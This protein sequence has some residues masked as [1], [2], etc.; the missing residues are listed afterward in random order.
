MSQGGMTTVLPW[1]MDYSCSGFE[2]RRWQSHWEPMACP[3]LPGG[4]EEQV[5]PRDQLSHPPTHPKAQL[6]NCQSGRGRS[7]WARPPAQQLATTI[8]RFPSRERC[9][10][11][12]WNPSV[13]A[14]VRL[15]ICLGLAW[16]KFSSMNPA[17]HRVEPYLETQH[18]GILMCVSHSLLLSPLTSPNLSP[19]PHLL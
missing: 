5:G 12:V 6:S 14:S 11:A 2:L 18:L 16:L 19:R 10:P 15:S 1:A 4:A 17:R 13:Y 3:E 8:P 9:T 7:P